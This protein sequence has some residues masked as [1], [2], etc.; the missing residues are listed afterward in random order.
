[1][2]KKLSLLLVS[3]FPAFFLIFL[4]YEFLSENLPV[5]HPELLN[6][7]F[8]LLSISA[9]VMLTNLVLIHY[10]KPQYTGMTFMA[11]TMI[12][13]MLVMGFFILFVLL[14]DIRLSDNFVF[15]LVITYFAYLGYELIF[16]VV[17]LSEE[18]N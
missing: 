12:K 15:V 1:M 18:E 3:V 9:L 11:W 5:K 10:F 6:N 17:L 16:G 8:L 2:S 7:L 4:F 13:I 14:E